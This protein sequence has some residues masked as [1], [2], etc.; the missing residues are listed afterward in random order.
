MDD[1]NLDASLQAIRFRANDQNEL[2]EV[3]YIP[4]VFQL[5]GIGTDAVVVLHPDYPDRVFKCYANDRL[6]KKE[7]EQ[8]VYERL[9]ES[10]YF[11]ELKGSGANY[12]AL[13]YEPGPTLYQCLEQGIIIPEDVIG[14]VEEARRYAMSKGLNPRD[15][16][17]KNVIL[18]GDRAKV[19]DVSEYMNP[20]NDRRW[21]D[22]V[23]GYR[24]FYPLIRGK[25]VPSWLMEAV[26]NI[27][28]QQQGKNFQLQE[29]GKKVMHLFGIGP[30]EDEQK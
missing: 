13:S 18:Q 16:H 3:E 27:Y 17:F 28:Y 4:A 12:L 21:D 19:I 11:A 26:K 20:G 25:K 29:F 1:I 14:Q 22:L 30:A 23:E 7:Q 8:R 9:G 24:L 10:P 15:I 6:G 2:V 5:I